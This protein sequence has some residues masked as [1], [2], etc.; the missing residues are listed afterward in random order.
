MAKKRSVRLTEQQKKQRRVIAGVLGFVI[1]GYMIF[2]NEDL[3][4]FIPLAIGIIALLWKSLKS[5]GE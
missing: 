4:G 2:F 5:F 3:L 1:G